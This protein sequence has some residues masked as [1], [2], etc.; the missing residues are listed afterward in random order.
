MKNTIKKISILLFLSILMMGIKITQPVLAEEGEDSDIM[1]YAGAYYN[2]KGRYLSLTAIMYSS[3]GEFNVKVNFTINETEYVMNPYFYSGSENYLHYNYYL[4]GLDYGVYEI[5]FFFQNSTD[6]YEYQNNFTVN[7]T[8]FEFDVVYYTNFGYNRIGNTNNMKFYAYWN[9]EELK[10][11]IENVNLNINGTS[12][13]MNW[14]DCAERYLFV[15]D[16]GIH[17]PNKYNYSISFTLG[18]EN[19]QTGNYSFYSK[20]YTET[21]SFGASIHPLYTPGSLDFNVELTYQTWQNVEPTFILEIDGENQT[22][23]PKFDMESIFQCGELPDIDWTYSQDLGMYSITGLEEGENH[24]INVYAF[25]GVNWNSQNLMDKETFS[26]P[27]AIEDFA[28]DVLNWNITSGTS[29]STFNIAINVTCPYVTNACWQDD[30]YMSIY[31]PWTQTSVYKS[32]TPDDSNDHD[33]SD[34]K[35]YNLTKEKWGY[36]EGFGELTGKFH[37]FYHN[38]TTSPTYGNYISSNYT[39]SIS[40]TPVAEFGVKKDDWFVY[41]IHHESIYQDCKYCN[42]EDSYYELIRVRDIGYE[43]GV[44][45]LDLEYYDWDKCNE[46]WIY[47]CPYYNYDLQT[48]YLSHF[49]LPSYASNVTKRIWINVN[50]NSSIYNWEFLPLNNISN[51]LED[52]SRPYFEDIVKISSKSVEISA[53]WGDAQNNKVVEFDKKGFLKESSNIVDYGEYHSYMYYTKLINYGNG[54]IPDN[55]KPKINIGTISIVIIILAISIAGVIII[56]KKKKNT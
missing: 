27:P 25:D 16:F 30:A 12:E 51:Y 19:Y 45:Y 43:L 31:G 2:E 41:E 50:D 13:A 22:L 40:E 56:Y 15:K 54:D 42:Y 8:E 32:M 29:L 21:S 10:K 44:N 5:K 4:C 48:Y 55:I 35:I 52:Y 17:N 47:D 9:S 7:I 46:T 49:S 24:T 20:N 36:K 3:S 18:N 6:T 11:E 1:T 38:Q 33:F 26:I 53:N 14:D 39:F 28:I 37:I 34:G 23:E